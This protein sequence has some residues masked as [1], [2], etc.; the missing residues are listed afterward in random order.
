MKAKIMAIILFATLPLWAFANVEEEFC[1]ID[2]RPYDHLLP[3]EIEL[4][5]EEVVDSFPQVEYCSLREVL[6]FEEEYLRQTRVAYF[7]TVFRT[8]ST[9]A[10][11]VSA[12]ALEGKV[13]GSTVG[14][15]QGC[16][17]GATLAFFIEDDDDNQLDKNYFATIDYINKIVGIFS[18]LSASIIAPL[19]KFKPNQ[20]VW[21]SKAVKTTAMLSKGTSSVM[22]GYF[23]AQFSS[24]ICQKVVHAGHNAF[25]L[26]VNGII[27]LDALPSMN[28]IRGDNK[29]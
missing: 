27:N 19:V 6:R 17:T 26:G 18:S 8:V 14:F 13:T 20:E 9:L 10:K 28:L 4:S 22:S 15:I 2:L 24:F 1:K 7:G 29:N 3:P 12:K 11:K 25:D 23:S 5:S 16:P 21:P